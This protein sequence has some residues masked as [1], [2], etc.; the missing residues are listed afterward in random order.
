MV[1][2]TLNRN[3]LS[4]GTI[5]DTFG[6]VEG[7]TG[8]RVTLVPVLFTKCVCDRC[9]WTSHS[10]ANYFT[11]ALIDQEGHVWCICLSVR[12]HHLDPF[13]GKGGMIIGWNVLSFS[14]HLVFDLL[15]ISDMLKVKWAMFLLVA[16]KPRRGRTVG[17]GKLS[18]VQ[19]SWPFNQCRGCHNGHGRS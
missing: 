14:T 8:P 12:S 13:G 2:S 17:A 9:A 19:N 5:L 16:L 7:L 1:R 6:L 4:A 10:T 18:P 15:Y 11:F 3:I